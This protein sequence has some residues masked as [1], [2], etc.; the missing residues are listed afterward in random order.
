MNRVIRLP[1]AADDGGKADEGDL[2]DSQVFD[3]VR[4]T[5]LN[6]ASDERPAA[7]KPAGHAPK[8]RLAKTNA[9]V[10]VKQS[11]RIIYETTIPRRAV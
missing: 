6:L 8:S 1:S 4:F 3:T 9:K 5:G 7:A 10:T 11:G 2:P